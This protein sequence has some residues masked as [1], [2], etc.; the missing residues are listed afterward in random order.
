ML[1]DVDV[2]FFEIGV[3]RVD[4]LSEVLHDDP[5]IDVLVVGG[6]HPQSIADGALLYFDGGAFFR[7]ARHQA[8]GAEGILF[9]ASEPDEICARESTADQQARACFSY[10]GVVSGA[11]RNGEVQVAPVG[12]QLPVVR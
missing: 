7:A 4:V 9:A 10:V 5:R 2:E 3:F 12:G 8:H 1:E 11:D 6:L